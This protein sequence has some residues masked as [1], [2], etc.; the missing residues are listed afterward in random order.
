MNPT[1]GRFFDKPAF[2][3]YVRMFGE[4]EQLFRE[5]RGESPEA[6]E[7]RDRMDIPGEQLDSEEIAAIHALPDDVLLNPPVHTDGQKA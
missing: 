6:D 4:L 5:G 3:E 1:P 7:L 2:R